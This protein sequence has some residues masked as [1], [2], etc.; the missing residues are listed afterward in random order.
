MSI[1]PRA[2]WGLLLRDLSHASI[3]GLLLLGSDWQIRTPHMRGI[4]QSPASIMG[5]PAG[6]CQSPRASGDPFSCLVRIGKSEPEASADDIIYHIYVNLIILIS[7]H[8]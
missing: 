2:S 4:C 6:I 7:I 8:I 1:P 5:P 3:G